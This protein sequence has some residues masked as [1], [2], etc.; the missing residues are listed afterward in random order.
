MS[1]TSSPWWLTGLFLIALGLSCEKVIE[2]PIPQLPD[3]L[4]LNGIFS[5]DSPWEVEL[6]ESGSSLDTL[7]LP[8][9]TLAR[10][11]LLNEARGENII[12]EHIGEGKYQH[13][14]I[15]PISSEEYHIQVEVPDFPVLTASSQVPAPVSATVVDTTTGTYLGDDAL[16]F[17]LEINDDPEVENFYLI[18][19]IR[20]DQRDGSA[21]HN[22]LASLDENSENDVF[23]EDQLDT[24]RIYLPDKQ[25][26]GLPYITQFATL[27]SRN[28]LFNR[29]GE[30]SLEIHL[31][32]VTED[33]YEYLK[34][35]ELSQLRDPTFSQPI[36]IH[37]NVDNGLGIFGGYTKQ[38]W[39]YDF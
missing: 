8:P 28:D 2:P 18:E 37:T 6:T 11:K 23:G 24:Q 17:Q 1:L 16:F 31:F 12:L 25:F 14:D 32:S 39:V 29:P 19:V 38:L 7:P 27:I 34:T 22:L 33:L 26:T 36:Q 13:P 20:R 4:V 21:F 15:Q 9:V 30:I 3:L 10:V 35:L 5:P